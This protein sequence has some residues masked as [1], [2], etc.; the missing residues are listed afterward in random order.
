MARTQNVAALHHQGKGNPRNGKGNRTHCI[1][2]H[3]FNEE[4]TRWRKDGAR[5]CRACRRKDE[6]G[7]QVRRAR[8]KLARTVKREEAEE[9]ANKSKLDYLKLTPE[10]S[11]AERMLGFAIEDTG[12]TP[13]YKKPELYQDYDERVPP[14][15]VEAA[16]LCIGCNVFEQC[17]A[18]AQALK[19][20]NGV[21]AGRV[22]IDGKPET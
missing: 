10:Q 13:C 16:K 12:P 20:K 18:F 22:W 2:G 11:E 19:P 14:S 9:L 3:E 6:A 21:W 5:E 1:H 4:N 7:R 8:D 15:M 17:E